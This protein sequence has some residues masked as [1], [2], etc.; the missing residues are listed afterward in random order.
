[1][2]VQP[3]ANPDQLPLFQKKEIDAAWTVEPWVSRLVQEAGGKVLVDDKSAITTVLVAR[4]DFL[5]T[6][7]DSGA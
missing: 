5:A 4:A 7:R 3:L 2:R 1:M 6:Q